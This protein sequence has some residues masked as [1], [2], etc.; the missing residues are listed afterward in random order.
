MDTDDL[1][2]VVPTPSGRRMIRIGS[3]EALLPR[4]NVEL[5]EE[6]LMGATRG[7]KGFYEQYSR[8]PGGNGAPDP[9]QAVERS[10]DIWE[11]IDDISRVVVYYGE[12]EMVDRT[13]SPL[14]HSLAFIPV[15]DDL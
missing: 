15:G 5:P 3:F 13:Y 1:N 12:N 10:Q 11:R 2:E 8:G 9:L 6:S 7:P 4:E 14:N